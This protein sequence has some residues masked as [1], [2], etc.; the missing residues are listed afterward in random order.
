MKVIT[1]GRSSNNDK[2]IRGD[3]YVS[4]NHCRIVQYNNGAFGIVDTSRNGTFVNGK[5][6]DGE[7]SLHKSDVVRIGNTT[8]CWYEWFEKEE[9]KVEDPPAPYKKADQT[10]LI[11]IP[12]E[13]SIKR[14]NAEIRK[15]GDDFSVGFFRK[16]GDNI[17]NHLGNTIGCIASIVLIVV[18]I[19]I[20]ALLGRGCA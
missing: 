18:F 5:R 1:V 11:N 8:L 12:S 13:I 7:T 19:A 15:R 14:E 9:P 17:G 16:M 10:P 2:V 3:E 20:V 4:G 6:I